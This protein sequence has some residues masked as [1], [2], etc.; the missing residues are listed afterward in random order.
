MHSTG[1]ILLE[2]FGYNSY[3]KLLSVDYNKRIIEEESSMHGGVLPR[4]VMKNVINCDL[5]A[6]ISLK[7]DA[8]SIIFQ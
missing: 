5:L 8:N 4:G 6:V 7:M 3:N 1:G 2:K